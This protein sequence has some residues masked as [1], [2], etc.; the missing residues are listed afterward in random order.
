M[1]PQVGQPL[2]PVVGT[3]RTFLGGGGE[4]GCGGFGGHIGDRDGSGGAG[5][6]G[7]GDG[8]IGDGCGIGGDGGAANTHVFMPV[9][10][11]QPLLRA[12]AS[13]Q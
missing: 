13:R 10:A 11:H 7:G 3:P 6:C 1:P 9:P 8:G 4:G 5:D 2:F 12:A